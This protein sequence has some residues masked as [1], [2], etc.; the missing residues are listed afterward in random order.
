M[1]KRADTRLR[2]MQHSAESTHIRNFLCEIEAEFK[3]ILGYL[4]RV[5]DS[6]KEFFF[7]LA[8]L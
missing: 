1:L 2:A 7:K 6:R 8:I 4:Y 5:N 3:N